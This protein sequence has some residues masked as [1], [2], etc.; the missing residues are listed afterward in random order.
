M[1]ENTDG[2]GWGLLW[3]ISKNSQSQQQTM[4]MVVFGA[5]QTL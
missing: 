2:A 5:S 1:Y 4:T 3:I